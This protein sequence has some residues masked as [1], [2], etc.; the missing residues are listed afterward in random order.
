MSLPHESDPRAAYPLPASE[1]HPSSSGSRQ[2]R[3]G[4]RALQIA[5][6]G[7]ALAATVAGGA[8]AT[9]HNSAPKSTADPALRALAGDRYNPDLNKLRVDN[10]ESGHTIT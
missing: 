5:G 6:A 1:I 3:L 7:A 4:R 9:H 2:R 8:L 10:N